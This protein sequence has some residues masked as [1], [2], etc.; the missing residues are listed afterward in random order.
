MINFKEKGIRLA[1]GIE[2]FLDKELKDDPR[3]VKNL[4]RFWGKKDGVEYEK[5]L[6]FHKCT[7]EDFEQFAPP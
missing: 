4:V 1:F 3:Y 5:L 2:G 7:E 6:P